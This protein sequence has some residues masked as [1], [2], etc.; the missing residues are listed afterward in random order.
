MKL[1]FIGCGNMAKAMMKGIVN[2]GKVAAADIYGSNAHA[3]SAQAVAAE[4]GIN[5]GTSNVAV[6]EAADIL[7]LSVKPYQYEDVIVEISSAVRE[8]Q[9]V[10]TVAPGKTIAWLEDKFTK[11]VRIV[12]TAPN[13]PAL[14]GEG[15]TAYCGNSLAT[16]EDIANVEALL[17]SFGKT[18][19]LK[20]NL[21][22]VCS[23][24]G[25][26][27]PAYVYMFIEALADAGVAE[28][29]PRA[30]A[31]DIAAQAV[32]GSAKMVLETGL[33]PGQLKDQVTS[34][35]GTTI[36]GLEYLERNAFRG[37]VIT[38]LRTAIN[39]GRTQ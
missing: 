10:V 29:L 17:S 18:L 37:T 27:T 28:G 5:A 1:G 6:A 14:V 24:V 3:E 13:T 33:H 39:A 2:S 8:S 9:V 35:S 12:R 21:I 31:Y 38:A 4:F 20:E 16:S 7:F 11:P 15:L 26:C 32:M 30:Q 34:P 25:G 36:K 19:Q 22:D 23:A